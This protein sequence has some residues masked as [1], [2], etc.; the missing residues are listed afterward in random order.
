V[1]CTILVFLLLP[2]ML[3]AHLLPLLGSTFALLSTD[4]AA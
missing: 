3:L 1:H 4:K 2:A